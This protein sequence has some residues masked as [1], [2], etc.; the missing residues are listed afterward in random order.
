MDWNLNDLPVFVAVVENQGITLAAQKLGMQKSSVSRALTRLETTLGFLLLE[1]NSRHIRPTVEGKKLYEQLKPTLGKLEDIAHSLN[2]RELDGEFK[3][4]LTL[5]FSREIFSPCA[6]E[7]SERHPKIVLNIRTIA[8]ELSIFD[9]DLD[10]IIQL[11]SLIPSGFYARHL[12]KVKLQWMTS[13]SYYRNNP[14][15]AHSNI[16]DL[17]NHVRFFHSQNNYPEK[18]YIKHSSGELT[19]IRFPSANVLEDVLMVREAVEHGAGVTLL[20]DIYCMRP[21]AEKKLVMI[22]PMLEVTPD[23]SIYAVYPGRSNM[24]P[25]LNIILNFLE[26]ITSKYIQKSCSSSAR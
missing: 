19:E 10:L 8:Q 4:A 16:N 7:F 6:A 2:H 1:R 5:A 22:S 21:V 25:R 24:S 23:V 20:P 14:G 9:D 12:C 13:P 11:G 15:L 17:A 26:E 3:L 18:F